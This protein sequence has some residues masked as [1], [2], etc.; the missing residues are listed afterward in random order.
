MQGGSNVSKVTTQLDEIPVARRLTP[1]IPQQKQGL[2]TLLMLVVSGIVVGTVVLLRPTQDMPT[3]TEPS[4]EELMPQPET[5]GRLLGHFSYPVAHGVDLVEVIP[6]RRLHRDAAAAF[7]AMQRDATAAGV[8]LRLLSAFRDR[9]TQ[10]S[11]FFPIMVERS[12][13]PEERAQVS[14]PPGYSEHH[15]GYALDLGDAR[16]PELDLDAAFDQSAAFAWLQQHASRY[17]FRLSFPVDNRQGVAYEPWHWRWEG[18]SHALELFEQAR[19]FGTAATPMP[20]H[21]N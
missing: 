14:A 11:L 12:Q 5:D 4:T 1:S 7:L 15:T 8:Q 10:H 16:H 13:R 6:G 18:S 19:R 17:H 20:Q 9:E 3:R 21:N 2:L